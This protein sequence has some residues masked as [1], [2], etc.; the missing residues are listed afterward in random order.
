MALL[1]GPERSEGRSSSDRLR[2]GAS[3]RVA[4]LDICRRGEVVAASISEWTVQ[5]PV[6]CVRASQR[7]TGVAHPRLSSRSASREDLSQRT[8][9]PS[10]SSSRRCPADEFARPVGCA[11]SLRL[12]SATGPLTRIRARRTGSASICPMGPGATPPRRLARAETHPLSCLSTR[13]KPRWTQRSPCPWERG[14]VW[15]LLRSH[16]R[17]WPRMRQAQ[18]GSR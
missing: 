3:G 8:K 10:V 14:W 12:T 13:E 6:G 5:R 17:W 11:A 15:T 1:D 9:T 16:R 4:I 7:R 18:E 2:C